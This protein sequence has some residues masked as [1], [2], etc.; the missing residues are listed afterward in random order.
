MQPC[1]RG[2]DLENEVSPEVQLVVGRRILTYLI[3]NPGARD[4]TDGI[5]D[6][7]LAAGRVEGSQAG[8]AKEEVEKILELMVDKQWL[9]GKKTD[10]SPKLYGINEEK[11]DEIETF[12]VQTPDKT[13]V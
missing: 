5:I 8:Q 3:E 13:D 1:A 9:I 11:I 10:A 12:L 7:W 2:L 6:W 4:T